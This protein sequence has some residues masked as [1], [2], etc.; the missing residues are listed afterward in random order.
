[1]TY[2]TFLRPPP[3]GWGD[4]N[5]CR[6]TRIGGLLARRADAFDVVALE[7]SFSESALRDLLDALGE[8]LPYRILRQPNSTFMRTNGGLTLLSAHPIESYTTRSFDTCSGADCLATKGFVHA[9][10]TLSSTLKLNVVATHLDAG[11][12]W[13]DRTARRRQLG[14]I[15]SY[16]E[17]NTSIQRWPTVLLGDMNVDG[18]AAP[19][20][21]ETPRSRTDGYREMMQRLGQ[22]CVSCQSALCHATCDRSPVDTFRRAHGPWPWNER[23][24]RFANTHNC[25]SESLGGCREPAGRTDWRARERLDYVFSF[26]APDRKPDF[27]VDVRRAGHWPLASDA[28]GTDYLSD[29]QAVTAEIYFRPSTRPPAERRVQR[30]SDPEGGGG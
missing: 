15:R 8:R 23:S 17:T 25:P 2:N 16:L 19:R 5:E 3:V 4:A 14:R 29:H 12:G 22:S 27:E 26:G 21:S 30:Q 18:L 24:T 7:E 28:C 1:L 13:G 20:G 10:L 6:A 9:V 11:D